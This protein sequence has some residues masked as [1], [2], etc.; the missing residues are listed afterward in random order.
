MDVIAGLL[1]GPRAR[2][3]FLLRSV[4]APP[5]SIRVQDEAPLA[6]VAVV[7][8]HAWVLPDKAEPVHIGKGDVVVLP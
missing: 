6:L 5:W 7:R 4:L 1:D 8:G 3:A 2:R